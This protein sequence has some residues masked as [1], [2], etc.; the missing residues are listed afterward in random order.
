MCLPKV[1]KNEKNV[2]LV[3]QNTEKPF[4]FRACLELLDWKG[5][6]LAKI[7]VGI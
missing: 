5:M 3:N 6:A 7:K 1:R 2:D 4:F